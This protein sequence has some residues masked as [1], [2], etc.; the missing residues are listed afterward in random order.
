MTDAHPA[1]AQCPVFAATSLSGAITV[2]TTEQGLPLSL[3][4]EAAEL[5]RDPAQLAGEILRLC[6]RSADRAGLLR[7][8]QL[9]ESGLSAQALALAGLPTPEDVARRE[10]LEEQEYDTEPGSWLRPV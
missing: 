5:R 8:T 7:R 6:R 2:R 3:S 1:D 10:A 4:I 9:E